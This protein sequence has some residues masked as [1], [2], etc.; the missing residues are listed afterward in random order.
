MGPGSVQHPSQ[1]REAGIPYAPALLLAGLMGNP[2]AARLPERYAWD[3][4]RDVERDPPSED[5]AAKFRAERL[6]RKHA[7]RMKRG[8]K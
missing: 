1:E 4:A 3:H 6:A 7:A 8:E 5:L 2:W